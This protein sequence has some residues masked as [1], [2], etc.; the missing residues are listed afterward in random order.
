MFRRPALQ[1]G[2]SIIWD[3]MASR[4]QGSRAVG[5][6]LYLTTRRFCFTATRLEHV[7]RGEDWETSRD[8][9]TW[10]GLEPPSLDAGPFSGGARTRLRLDVA[11][12]D[13]E[14]FVVNGLGETPALLR[15][16]LGLS[17]DDTAKRSDDVVRSQS[18]G[19]VARALPWPYWLVAL[20]ISVW[21]LVTRTDTALSST[22]GCRWLALAGALVGL[23]A[24]VLCGLQ[25]LWLAKGRDERRPRERNAG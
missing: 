19:A 14:L 7:V 2:E 17:G 15:D 9:V 21:F 11:D 5:G 25:L 22:G 24:A 4:T 10:I 1:D 23:I 3:A 12:R 18:R 16:E 13:V 6:R 8:A 20:A